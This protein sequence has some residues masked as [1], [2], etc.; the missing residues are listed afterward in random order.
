MSEITAKHGDRP[1][2]KL[3][4]ELL[5]YLETVSNLHYLLDWNVASPDR[6][7]EL[8]GLED[9]AFQAMLQRVLK[10]LD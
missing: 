9:E 4:V 2:R 8:R 7:K 6:L 1:A 3:A 10:H 5:P